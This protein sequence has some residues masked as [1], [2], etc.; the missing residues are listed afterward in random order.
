MIRAVRCS[1]AYVMRHIATAL[2]TAGLRCARAANRVDYVQFRGASGQL[3]RKRRII[4]GRRVK[5][6]DRANRN[7]T[8][9][10]Q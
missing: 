1:I 6:R 4:R 5:D 2:L 9:G 7:S 10:R 3:P 8:L